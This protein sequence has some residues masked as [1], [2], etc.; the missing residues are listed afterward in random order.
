M[1]L[2]LH[3]LEDAIGGLQA[4]YE[5]ESQVS[6]QLQQRLDEATRELEISKSSH[7]NGS[8]T[9][10]PASPSK[11]DVHAAREEVKGLK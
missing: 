9:S 2:M 6:I 3:Q 5:Q 4:K 8:V 10:I 7:V 11:H 1:M